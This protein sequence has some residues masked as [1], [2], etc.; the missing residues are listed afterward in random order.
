MA[1]RAEDGAVRDG[2]PG[3]IR[4]YL[5][6]GGCRDRGFNFDSEGDVFDV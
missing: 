1:E 2:Q 5:N 4:P 3:V 6:R